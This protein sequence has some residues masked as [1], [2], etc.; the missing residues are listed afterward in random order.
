M[1]HVPMHRTL[2]DLFNFVADTYF[3]PP[4]GHLDPHH[5]PVP[6]SPTTTLVTVKDMQKDRHVTWER[7]YLVAKTNLSIPSCTSFV[8]FIILI[9]QALKPTNILGI[10]MTSFRCEIKTKPFFIFI[11]HTLISFQKQ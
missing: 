10:H 7:V 5:Y 9:D 1:H 4:L 2:E 8:F 3:E 11:Q 6:I